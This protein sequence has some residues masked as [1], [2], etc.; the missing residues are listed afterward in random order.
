MSKTDK[1]E[2]TACRKKAIAAEYLM[3]KSSYRNLGKKYNL[4]FRVIHS[5]VIKFQ[6]TTIIKSSKKDEEKVVIKPSSEKLS[7]KESLRLEKLRN[8]LLNAIIDI[9]DKD[10]NIN[11]RKKFGTKQ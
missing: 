4:D 6:A 5:W 3:R 7:L 1:T 9:A 2:L 10:L 11:R 8:E